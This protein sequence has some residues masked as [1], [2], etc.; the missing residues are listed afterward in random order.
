MNKKLIALAVSAGLAMP[1]FANAAEVAGKALEIYGKVHVSIDSVSAKDATGGSNNNTSISGNS[2]RLGFK[3]EG[4]VGGMTGF[5]KYEASIKTDEGGGSI[6]HRGA[7]IGLKGSGGSVLVG[8]KDT[9]FKDVRG[10]FDIFGDTVGDARNIMG[11]IDGTDTFNVR[12]TNVLEYSSP[13]AGG[14]QANVMYSTAYNKQETQGQDNNDHSLTSLNL[15]Y[16]ANRL[17]VA[18][19]YEEHKL[20]TGNGKEKGWLAPMIWAQFVL[21]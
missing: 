21:A 10:M 18:A 5:Y 20:G 17:L 11:S 8:Y 13:N 2:S 4:A 15:K 14:F 7:Y 3:G 16:K 19:G 9:P 1:G 12:A 6:D